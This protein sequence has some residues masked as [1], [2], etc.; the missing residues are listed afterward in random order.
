MVALRTNKGTPMSN[1][2][3]NMPVIDVDSHWTEPPDLWTSRA[4]AKF[5]DRALRFRVFGPQ[6]IEREFGA[7]LKAVG[8][9]MPDMFVVQQRCP[10]IFAVQGKSAAKCSGVFE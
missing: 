4:P 1:E 5:K 3:A 9:V 10:H 2:L 7:Q 6:M 8:A